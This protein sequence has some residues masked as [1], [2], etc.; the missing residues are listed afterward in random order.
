LRPLRVLTSPRLW[1][2]L[3]FVLLDLPAGLLYFLV[4]F[5]LL[6]VGVGTLPLGVGFILLALAPPLTRLGAYIERQRARWLLDEVIP[7]P[8]AAQALASEDSVGRLPPANRRSAVFRWVRSFFRRSWKLAQEGETWRSLAYLLALY[9]IG[10]LVAFAVKAQVEVFRVRLAEPALAAAQGV[11][12]TAA[13]PWVLLGLPGRGWIVTLVSVLAGLIWVLADAYLIIAVASMHRAF[14]RWL[15]G[16][17]PLS[18]RARLEARVRA[19][20][21][22][23]TRLLDAVLQERQRLERDLHDGAQQRLVALALNLGMAR[24]KITTQPEVAEELIVR[25]HEESKRA[26]AELRDLVRGIHPAV[27]TDRGLDAALSALAARCPAP[28]SVDVH[29]PER[30]SDAVE[31]TAYFAAAEALANIAKHS[32]ATE[33][34]IEARMEERQ[35]RRMFYLCVRDNGRGGANAAHGTGLTGIADRVAALDGRL[36][37]TSPAGGPTH[38]VVE[39]PWRP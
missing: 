38:L 27:L 8:V 39:L 21:Q 1:K 16:P 29:L 35:G 31:A 6:S 15:L 30:P 13:S 37:V 28:V 34:H 3:V 17:A 18:E 7:P 11:E 23:R 4:L 20:D 2:S 36:I 32:G 33:A 25:A 19:I 5:T 22:S 26:L 24:E 10:T 14:A 12:G 9:P